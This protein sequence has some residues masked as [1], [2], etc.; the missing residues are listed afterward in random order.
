M[1]INILKN[2]IYLLPDSYKLCLVGG[3]VR[4]LLLNREVNDLDCL[5]VCGDLHKL[6]D[7]LE[8][9]GITVIKDGLP[10]LHIRFFF[11]GTEIE[12]SVPRKEAYRSD[13]RNPIVVHG[14]LL[15]EIMR[16]D[17]TINSLLLDLN[18]FFESKNLL[19][20][21]IDLSNG[22]QDI[23]KR[24][25][26]SNNNPEIMLNEDPVRVL[27]ALRFASK[28]NFTIEVSLKNAIVNF[29]VNRFDIVSK[30]RIR[31]EFIKCVNVN[32]NFFEYENL[33]KHF[34]GID[35]N[36]INNKE[37]V[38]EHINKAIQLSDTTDMKLVALFHD[39]GKFYTESWNNKQSRF[40]YIGHERISTDIAKRFLKEYKFTNKQQKFVVQ[41]VS[42]HMN[43]KFIKNRRQVKQIKYILKHKEYINSLVKFNA[44]DWLSKPVNWQQ[45]MNTNQKQKTIEKI[46]S[47]ILNNVPDR[48]TRK[49]IAKKKGNYTDNLA[50]Y[51]RDKIANN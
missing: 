43:I 10:F 5:L 23:Q 35:I 22:L 42:E 47:T 27:R 13:S 41:I 39:L 7:I 49:N 30:E 45:Q 15:E 44:I 4:D 17:F 3:A 9:N 12:V 34:F 48:D 50:I 40:A 31:D 16:R 36:S 26:R 19:K 32:V 6:I 11:N 25:I 38:I 2:L 51:I 46:V 29:D 18:K 37:A 24:V 8:K 28:Y 33:I 14:T 1:D 20:S 21:I